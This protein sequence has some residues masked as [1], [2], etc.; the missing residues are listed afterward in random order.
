MKIAVLTASRHKN[1]TIKDV[2]GGYGTVFTIGDSF[3]AR[4]LEIAKRRIAS[5]P[6]VSVAYL[7]SLLEKAGAQVVIK[8]N[9]LEP[10]DLYLISSSI[11]DC[12]YEKELGAE[13]RKKYGA[14]VGY[15]GTFA[16]TVPEFYAET[17]DFVLKSEIENIAPNLAKGEIP[18]GVA[19][20]GFVTD[21]DSLPFPNWDQFPVHKYKYSIVTG[22]GI[23]LPMLASRG[24]PYTCGYCP[25]LVNAKYR[26]RSPESVVEEIE[27]LVRKYGIKGI[28]FRD[29]VFTFD[30]K[31]ALE[32]AE[33]ILRRGLDIRFG[34]EARTDKLDDELLKVLYRAGLRSVEIGIESANEKILLDNLRKAPGKAQQ[35]KVV[36]ACHHLG[37][38]VIGNY[39]LG[40]SN[41][42]EEGIH[43]T[44]DYAKKLNTFAIQFTVTTPYPGTRFYDSIQHRIF[45]TDWEKFNGWTNVYKHPSI[46]STELHRLREKAYVSYHL[47][48][49]YVWR[50]L[51]STLLRGVPL[52]DFAR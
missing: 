3:F 13:V 39:I 12:N 22:Q 34:I 15:F 4:L 20:A 38:R 2:A 25:Y 9:E 14:R 30:R 41:D 18:Q 16:A 10:A 26:F 49:R 46:S 45:E 1:C 8:H 19:D 37:I 40:L 21:L 35:E 17:A 48:P 11:V 47:R 6:N 44:I 42:T 52:P 32:I 23:T 51:I 33:L 29:P 28:T 50:F 5:I 24:C 43:Q 36:V 7:H 27:Y 31:R